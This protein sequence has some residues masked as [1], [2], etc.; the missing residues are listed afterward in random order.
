MKNYIGFSIVKA[1]PMLFG[2][3][4]KIKD[5][6][7]QKETEFEDG[8]YIEYSDGHICWMDKKLF[9]YAA[10][11]FNGKMQFDYAFGLLKQGIK[12]KRKKWEDYGMNIYIEM[13]DGTPAMYFN[14]KKFGMWTPLTE[15]IMANDWYVA[16]EV[17]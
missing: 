6:K 12:I 9:E 11:E 7:L 1:K 13:L 17:V 8:Y 10:S 15:D 5:I 16:R 3:Y 4:C 14:D 2:E